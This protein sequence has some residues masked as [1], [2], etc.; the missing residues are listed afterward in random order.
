MLLELL[1]ALNLELCEN[2]CFFCMFTDI[3]KKM[4]W[5]PPPPPRLWSTLLLASFDR[6]CRRSESELI[7][8]DWSSYLQVETY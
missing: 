4:D 7:S 5:T 6:D 1:F 2:E 3:E 8:V